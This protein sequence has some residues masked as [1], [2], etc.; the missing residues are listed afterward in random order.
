M[1]L[2]LLLLLPLAIADRHAMMGE[3]QMLVKGNVL[4]FYSGKTTIGRRNSVRTQILQ[5][6]GGENAFI[7]K[8]ECV[9]ISKKK[10]SCTANVPEK[11]VWGK[12]NV[13]CEGYPHR[14]SPH[15]LKGSCQF[16][17]KLVKKWSILQIIAF[18]ILIGILSYSAPTWVPLL[19][20]AILIF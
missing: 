12:M 5:I 6:P 15:I 3:K 4:S 9:Y 11:Y 17:Y 2:L 8:V 13:D 20:M 10:W 1:K 18:C 7:D 19:C 16:Q 14:D